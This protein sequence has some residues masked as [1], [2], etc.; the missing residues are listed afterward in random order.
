M[1]F[2]AWQFYGRR[3]AEGIQK[4]ESGGVG[5]AITI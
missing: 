5:D 3:S 4:W 2:A 1:L